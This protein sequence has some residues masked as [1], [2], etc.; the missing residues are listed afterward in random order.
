[1]SGYLASVVGKTVIGVDVSDDEEALRFRCADGSTVVWDT[2]GDCCSETWWADAY[3]LN[4]LR[5][6]SVLSAE[7]IALPDYNVEDGRSRQEEDEVYG[8]R[9]ATDKGEACF[10]FRN[11]SNGYY[12][13]EAMLGADSPDISWREITGN[14]WSA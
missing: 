6:A 4:A 14:E 12:G 9:I 13:G 2:Y 7:E 8:V 3:E 5:G 1:L 10:A 11:S